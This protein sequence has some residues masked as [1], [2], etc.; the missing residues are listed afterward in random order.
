MKVIKVIKTSLASGP[1]G[2]DVEQMVYGLPHYERKGV[3]L[4]DKIIARYRQSLETLK[5]VAKD[6]QFEGG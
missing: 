6:Y 3:P 4:P 1:V 5:R 2:L